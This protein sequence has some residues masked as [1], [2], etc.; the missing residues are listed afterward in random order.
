MTR[1]LASLAICLPLLSLPAVAAAQPGQPP[2]PPPPGSSPGYGYGAY[3]MTVPGVHEHEGFFLRLGFGVG[4]L[5]MKT[6]FMDDDL[7]I[8][9]PAGHLQVAL[10]GNLSP[11]LILFG[12]LF[13]NAIDDPTVE[14]GGAEEEVDDMTAS[15]GAV[16]IGLAYYL[17]ANVYFSGTLAV[18]QLRLE[19]Q[20]DGNDAE[21]EPG[22][23]FLA[24]IGKEWWASDNWGLGIA[25]QFILS[26]NEDEED[27]EGP[28][29]V[30]WTTLGFGV[31]F[32][33]TYD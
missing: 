7:E 1:L 12:Q 14:F 9:G 32:S 22:P 31:L 6:E 24:Q 25:G 28:I 18:S 15:L 5:G 11:N 30:T 3:G 29:D 19:D 4:Y 8:K 33:A 13:V 21:S 16:G 17:P 2:P 27:A 20:N 10:G 26:S 23:A